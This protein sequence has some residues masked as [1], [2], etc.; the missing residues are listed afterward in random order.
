[1]W[2]GDMLQPKKI[3]R[4]SWNHAIRCATQEE[5]DKRSL[6]RIEVEQHPMGWLEDYVIEPYGCSIVH[7]DALPVVYVISYDHFVGYDCS[8]H[9][10]QFVCEVHG[11]MFAVKY[12]LEA[13]DPPVR[14]YEG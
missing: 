7:C 10:E 5:S 13:P 8:V 11:R 1:M 12:G 14:E 3:S 2:T 9:R 4:P 6:T